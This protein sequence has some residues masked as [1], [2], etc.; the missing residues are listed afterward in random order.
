MSYLELDKLKQHLIDQ[1][2]CSIEYFSLHVR[3]INQFNY[4]LCF[5]VKTL[6]SFKNLIVSHLINP[7]SLIANYSNAFNFLRDEI[8]SIELNADAEEIA[9]AVDP[10]Q[11]SKNGSSVAFSVFNSIND[12]F[13]F[14]GFL[15]NKS[16]VVIFMTC[17]H[18]VCH[19]LRNK[20]VPYINIGSQRIELYNGMFLSRYLDF[21]IFIRTKY[22]IGLFEFDTGLLFPS[23]SDKILDAYNDFEYNTTKVQLHS[24]FNNDMGV[25]YCQIESN[26][27]NDPYDNQKVLW[28][29]KCVTTYGY[30]GSPMLLSNMHVVGIHCGGYGNM[31]NRVCILTHD[32][33]HMLATY[34][35]KKTKNIYSFDNFIPN[36]PNYIQIDITS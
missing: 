2:I 4:E 26:M 35:K 25:T 30:S 32:I 29:H 5:Q 19:C 23:S 9:P 8:L 11:I 20:I 14:T 1:G 24:N 22:D 10:I 7:V 3:Y 13:L 15:V 36:D 31:F 16:N 12:K 6:E 28:G 17:A 27:L 33:N 21:N 18:C 34:F